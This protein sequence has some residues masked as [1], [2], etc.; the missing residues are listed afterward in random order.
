[1]IRIHTL[2]AASALALA[3]L[4]Q[5]ASALTLYSNFD[6]LAVMPPDYQPTVTSSLSGSCGTVTCGF[7]NAF[8]VGFT[9]TP[10][11][12]GEAGR[13]YIPFELLSKVPGAENIYG[14]TITNADDEIVARGGITQSQIAANTVPGTK[15]VYFDLLPNN[16]AGQAVGSGLM[17]PDAPQLDLGETYT[18]Y[19]EQSF[20]SLSQ[21]VAHEIELRLV[22]A[23]GSLRAEG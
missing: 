5:P 13:A 19:Y 7:I 18:A 4:A 20:G 6:P 17:A 16:S 12:S 2:A 8:S 14:L 15:T 23:A 3:A 10:T 1:M 9:F 11:A 22:S 21:N